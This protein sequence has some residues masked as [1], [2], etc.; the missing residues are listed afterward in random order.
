[1]LFLLLSAFAFGYGAIASKRSEDGGEK[2]RMR[3]DL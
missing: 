2:V 1:M 3:A